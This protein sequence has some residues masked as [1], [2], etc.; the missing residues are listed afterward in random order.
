MH[1]LDV[2][3]MAGR[4]DFTVGIWLL[5]AFEFKAR[6]RLTK[7]VLKQARTAVMNL[8]STPIWHKIWKNLMEPYW[9]DLG[10]VALTCIW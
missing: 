1:V 7:S 5:Q 2:G 9:H 6:S 10:I 8:D 3:R 4:L